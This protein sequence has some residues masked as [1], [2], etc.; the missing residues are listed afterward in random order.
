MSGTT[1]GKLV[2]EMSKDCIKYDE[3]YRNDCLS[4]KCC[5]ELKSYTLAGRKIKYLENVAVIGVITGIVAS[6][7][8]L[9]MI[10][11]IGGWLGPLPVLCVSIWGGTSVGLA[12]L[13]FGVAGIVSY[14]SNKERHINLDINE[15]KNILSNERKNNTHPKVLENLTRLEQQYSNNEEEF[16]EL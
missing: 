3:G 16:F 13:G 8:T 7:G 4:R 10:L 9:A 1:L 12:T 6:L 11:F 2:D 14:L 15:I 5:N